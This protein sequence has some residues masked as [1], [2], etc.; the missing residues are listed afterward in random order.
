[1]DEL[2]IELVIE[3]IDESVV[4]GLRFEWCLASRKTSRY[5]VLQ[6]RFQRLT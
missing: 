3:L 4:A 1:M 5:L 2:V 6:T